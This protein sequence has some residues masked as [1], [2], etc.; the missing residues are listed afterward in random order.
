MPEVKMGVTNAVDTASGLVI[1]NQSGVTVSGR[2]T[3]VYRTDFPD[4]SYLTGSSTSHFTFT[5]HGAVTTFT[6]GG[7]E[8]RTIYAADGTPTGTVMIHAVTHV[9]A[10]ADT[11]AV[12]GGV[13]RFFFTCM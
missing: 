3:F 10:D 1:A 9:T 7:V 8:P 5:A 11:G 12:I 6:Q 13:D 4:G 2:E